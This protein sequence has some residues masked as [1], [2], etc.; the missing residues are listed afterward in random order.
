MCRFGVPLAPIAE[1]VDGPWADGVRRIAADA[2]ITVIVG[3]FTPADDG[4]VDQHAA[5][6]RAAGSADT[7][8]D[9]I[10]L[11]DAFGFTES[12]TVAPGREP[13]VIT[14]D[15][16]GVGLTHLLRHPLPRTVHHAGPP[17]RPADR[18]Q[19]VVGCRPRKAGAVD[20][21]G[22]RPGAGLHQL[23]RRGRAG[24]P[25]RAAGLERADRGRRQPGG[26]AVRRRGGLGGSRSAAAGHRPRPRSGGDRPARLSRCCATTQRSL[27]VIRQNRPGDESA[28]TPTPGPVDMGSSRRARSAYP[29]GA[30][31][32]S[33]TAAHEPPA[34][35]A[36]QTCRRPP[37]NS[38]L[39]SPYGQ[40]PPQDPQLP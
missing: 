33:P 4:R 13:V 1:P 14:V 30:A 27:M 18:R 32:R 3:M 39:P 7:H 21:A 2:N 5:R 16:V 25:R 17:R 26:F 40:P 23:H 8:Y 22:P 19:R 20:A 35:P 12:R 15:G 29:A 9:K 31:G 34:Q 24:R 6:G 36:H 38:R 11:Y 37:W 10:H 28:G